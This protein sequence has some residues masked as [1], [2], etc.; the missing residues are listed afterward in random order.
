MTLGVLSPVQAKLSRKLLKTRFG[1]FGTMT[2]FSS[3]KWTSRHHW[4]SSKDY[5]IEQ[6]LLI[7]PIAIDLM[8]VS[9]LK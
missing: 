1:G 2:R 9:K 3:R 5:V 7:Q 4:S 6:R 8:I